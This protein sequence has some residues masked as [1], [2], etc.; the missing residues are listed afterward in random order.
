MSVLLQDLRYGMR[1]LGKN[2]AFTT[3]AVL[4]LALGISAN[5]TV[6]SIVDG[7]SPYVQRT[8]AG[9]EGSVPASITFNGSSDAGTLTWLPC[10]WSHWLRSAA[11]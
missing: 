10:V 7:H 11:R 9:P 4:S 8:A 3:V 1:M 2:A 6:F 5:S